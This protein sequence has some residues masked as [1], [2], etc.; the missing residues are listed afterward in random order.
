MY[1]CR[2]PSETNVKMDSES[3]STVDIP[4]SSI[5]RSSAEIIKVTIVLTFC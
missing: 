1:L 4:A 5:I 2:T 3:T